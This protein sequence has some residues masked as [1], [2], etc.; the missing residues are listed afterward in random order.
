MGPLAEAK[1]GNVHAQMC[2]NVD[3]LSKRAITGQRRGRLIFHM[4]NI[5][6]T[7]V[8]NTCVYSLLG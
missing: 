1:I 6:A 7:S 2:D 4:I 8:F 5:Y 3:Y